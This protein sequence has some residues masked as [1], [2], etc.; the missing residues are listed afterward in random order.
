MRTLKLVALLSVLATLAVAA[1]VRRI[2]QVTGTTSQTLVIGHVEKILVQCGKTG[3]TK[4]VYR[5]G[6]AA[7]PPTAVTT[8]EVLDFSVSLEAY[9]IRIPQPTYDRIAFLALDGTSS[10]TCDVYEEKP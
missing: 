4:V 2:G 6:N 5:L 1:S 9:R 7:N 3:A 8:D 10:F